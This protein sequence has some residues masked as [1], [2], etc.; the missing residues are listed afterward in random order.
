MPP[1][2]YLGQSAEIFYVGRVLFAL[3]A[4][5]LLWLEEPAGRGSANTWL[6]LAF[7]ALSLSLLVLATTRAPGD[8]LA[9]TLHGGD[10]LFG[11][12]LL[13]LAENSVV[14]FVMWSTFCLLS[15]SSQ[16]HWKSVAATGLILGAI[17]FLSVA[18][19][20][21]GTER[22][23]IRTTYIVGATT[24]I[25]FGTH[26]RD[27]SRLKLLKLAAWASRPFEET[28]DALKRVLHNAC[29][30]LDARQIVVFWREA[31]DGIWRRAHY[32][33]AGGGF[34]VSSVTF[35]GDGFL[36]KPVQGRPFLWCATKHWITGGGRLRDDGESAIEALGFG[37]QRGP[38]CSVPFVG[39]ICEGRLFAMELARGR[40]E[41][42]IYGELVAA[43]ILRRLEGSAVRRQRLSQAIEQERARWSRDLHDGLLQSMTAMRLQL[44]AAI[45]QPDFGVLQ[46][47]AEKASDVL[48]DE[49]ERLRMIVEGTRQ[50]SGS[51]SVPLRRLAELVDEVAGHWDLTAEVDAEPPHA[52][53]PHR[54]FR[55]L[56]FVVSEAIANA[57]RHGPATHIKVD[58]E[59]Q[60]T[61][62]LAT[63]S[64][65]V[66]REVAVLAQSAP[67]SMTERV[68][69][70][71]GTLSFEVE[72]DRVVL[73]IQ[74]PVHE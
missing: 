66:S 49:Q 57:A 32:E 15:S 25:A 16:W 72:A 23:L 8:R 61:M 50:S 6:P 11:L 24:L 20:E 2:T 59:M 46:R 62:L 64:N 18:V 29:E 45:A 21:V 1:L 36:P 51:K 70:L 3:A 74:V 26:R 14:L 65:P 19:G 12:I 47:Q 33:I 38:I 68:L 48:R 9:V 17:Y 22:A 56:S 40:S 10:L 13:V 28:P 42:L 5:L 43:H 69:D 7:A 73:A 71:G 54:I 39:Q 4:A 58:L 52:V 63:F 67:R 34:D 44:K 41:Y 60:K 37:P 31:V 53:I 55:E 35:E 27:R 30:V